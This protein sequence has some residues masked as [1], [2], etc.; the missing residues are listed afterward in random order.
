MTTMVK[1]VIAHVG[2]QGSGK[3]YACEELIK[4]QGFK[5]LS[6]A[7]C[8]RSMAFKVL[9]LKYR[10]GMK[11]YTELKSTEIYNGQTFRN[12][13]ENLGSA[14]RQHDK[15][16]FARAVVNKIHKDKIHTSICIDDLRY[17]N[18]YLVLRDYCKQNNIK[19][20][21]VFCDYTSDRYDEENQHESTQLSRYLKG[22]GYKHN[23]IVRGVD[24]E[25]FNFMSSKKCEF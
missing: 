5:K 10:D 25:L 11:N 1:Q 4:E 15:D 3:S 12:I 24:I 14:I 16:F 19:F 9:G 2:Y 22:L 6:F 13:L 20:T 18:E 23:Q 7:D 8:L 17:V 21:L